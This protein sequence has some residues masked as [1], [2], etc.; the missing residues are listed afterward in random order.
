VKPGHVEIKGQIKID[1]VLASKGGA[2]PAAIPFTRTLQASV[3]WSDSIWGKYPL[4]AK[5]G[6]RMVVFATIKD[7]QWAIW[8]ISDQTEWPDAAL[9]SMVTIVKDAWNGAPPREGDIDPGQD[10]LGSSH[11]LLKL[12]ESPAKADEKLRQMSTAFASGNVYVRECAYELA[13][14]SIGRDRDAETDLNSALLQKVIGE[15]R[16]A[17]DYDLLDKLRFLKGF[18]LRGVVKHDDWKAAVVAVIRQKKTPK[19]RSAMD[20]ETY[21]EIVEEIV[22]K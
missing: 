15:I 5:N 18:A 3:Y 17:N 22:S 12:M 11:A 10:P 2:A 8:H 4:D 14:E 1:E 16:E 6:A 21:K 7:G 20:K 19:L 13:L 9:K